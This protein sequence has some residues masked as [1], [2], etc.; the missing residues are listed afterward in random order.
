MEYTDPREALLGADT[1]QISERPSILVIDDEIGPRE[2]LRILLKDEYSLSLAQNGNEG[3][4]MLKSSRFDVVILDLRMPGKSG[5]ETLE[6]IRKFDRD[7]PVIILTGFGTLE[8][9]QKA[10]HLN[11]FEFVSKPFDV[12]EIKDIVK[13]AVEK[14]RISR[15]TYDILRKLQKL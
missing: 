11:I 3:I 5:L 1:P 9:A 2:S 13:R 4:S 8:S 6:E 15:L 7:I 10:V 14:N 12:N